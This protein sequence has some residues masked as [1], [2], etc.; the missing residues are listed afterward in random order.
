MGTAMEWVIYFFSEKHGFN[1]YLPVFMLFPRQ[2][3]SQRTQFFVHYFNSIIE[4]TITDEKSFPLF[5]WKMFPEKIFY[6]PNKI[7][8]F[9][10]N[11]TRKTAWENEKLQKY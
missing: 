1:G 11:Q 2:T 10:I 5:N 7:I 9:D 3:K 4:T 8:N 6:I